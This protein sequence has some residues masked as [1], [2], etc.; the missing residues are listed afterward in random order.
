[1]GV[2][3]QSTVHTSD[4]ATGQ[5][6]SGSRCQS[7]SN[8][9]NNLGRTVVDGLE[10]SQECCATAPSGIAR[11]LS[12]VRKLAMLRDRSLFALKYQVS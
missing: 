7:R 8:R 6:Q 1:M 12:A 5:I 4:G 9:L 3:R 10:L 11:T 2:T